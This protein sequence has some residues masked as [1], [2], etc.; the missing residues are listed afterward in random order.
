[1]IG[2]QTVRR[3]L[4]R[5]DQITTLQRGGFDGEVTEIRGSITDA[6]AVE[7]A[8]A[9][10]DAVV[11][12]AARVGATG[13]WADFE[14]TN[15]LG[16]GTLVDAA[17]RAGVRRFV[18]VSSPSV[19]H[20]GRSLVGAG[21]DP[22]DPERARGFYARSKAMGE[23]VAL[24]GSSP[25][26]PVVAIRPHLIWGPGDTQLVGRVVDRARRGRLAVVG[27]GTALVDTIYV[28]NAA[29][30][31]VAALDRAPQLAGRAF[32]ISNGQPRTAAELTARV[33]AAAGLTVR[34]RHVP[35]WLAKAGGS[36][37]EQVWART[38]RTDDPPMTRFLA[39]QLATAHW[40][41]QAETRAALHW[42]PAVTLGEGFSRLADWYRTRPA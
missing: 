11:H 7:F 9:D 33:L 27:S 13:G 8:C 34:P 21:S 39:E 20:A 30:A 29:D 22:A 6:G 38:G 17:R 12:L 19:A 18:H 2:R 28:D 31:L 25:D 35:T 23:I 40:F 24:D 41:R 14:Q 37:V 5:G 16:V 3:L 32:V 15:V 1:L 36:L 10:Q 42:V 4:A 26:L